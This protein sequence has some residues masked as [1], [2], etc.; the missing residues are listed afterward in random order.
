[1]QYG[2]VDW[3]G[4][5]FV[6][7]GRG[8]AL[9][10]VCDIDGVL[11]DCSHRLHHIEKEPPDW[12]AFFAECP[13]DKPIPEGLV[14]LNY[15]TERW[16]VSDLSI[17]N[18]YLVTGRG[19]RWRAQTVEW[20]ERCTNFFEFGVC[21]EFLIM[22][23]EGDHRPDYILK[24]EAYNKIAEENPGYSLLIIDDNIRNVEEA[25]RRGYAAL[26]FRRPG[27]DRNWAIGDKYQAMLKEAPVAK[28]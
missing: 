12:E 18:T 8:E 15:L 6:G 7:T 17:A 24:G 28:R 4:H 11:A 23:P 22:R 25:V 14:L 13:D 26:H 3:L 1:V 27:E 10:V 16:P 19:E 9:I 21:H 2:R 20:L 5:L